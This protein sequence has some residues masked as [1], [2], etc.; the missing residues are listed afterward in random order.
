[1]S[2]TTFWRRTATLVSSAVLMATGV[3]SAAAPAPATPETSVEA[4]PSTDHGDGEEV[5]LVAPRSGVSLR[6]GELPSQGSE[7]TVAPLLGPLDALNCHTLRRPG[8]VVTTYRAKEQ[9]GFSGGRIKL[10]CGIDDKYGYRH[11]SHRH[12]VDWIKKMQPMR[13]D[14]DDFMDF[15]TRQ[16]L[17]APS[18]STDQGGGKLCYTTLVQ[19]RDTNGKIL[20][21]FYPRIIVSKNNRTV[22]TSFPGRGAD[23]H[24]GDDQDVQRVHIG[25]ALLRTGRGLGPGRVPPAPRPLLP[26]PGMGG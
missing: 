14:G 13:G 22:V 2:L 25:L 8:H 9:P 5:V 11:I 16:S 10:E 24:T 15:A 1:M 4:A 3:G 7:L 18:K 23:E 26:G 6:T 17:A 21:T 19:V 20:K 12:Q